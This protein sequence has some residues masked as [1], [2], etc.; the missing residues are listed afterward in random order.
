MTIEQIGNISWQTAN[1]NRVHIKDMEISHLVNTL[2][3]IQKHPEKFRNPEE[4]YNNL[5]RYA[6]HQK[7]FLFMDKKPYPLK[8]DSKWKLYNPEKG[9]TVNTPPPKEYVDYVKKHFKDH[10]DFQHYFK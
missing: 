10:A 7:I 8:V 5:E 9:K 1:G 6:D 3:W 4:L 2:N